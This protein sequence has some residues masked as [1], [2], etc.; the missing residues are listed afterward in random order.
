LGIQGFQ[1][2]RPVDPDLIRL[3]FPQIRRALFNPV[4][5]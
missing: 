5:G 3:N 1:S 2:I 4:D